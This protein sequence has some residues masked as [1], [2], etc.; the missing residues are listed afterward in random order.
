QF[1]ARAAGP[2]HIRSAVLHLVPFQA[3]SCRHAEA[4]DFEIDLAG[5]EIDGVAIGLDL[6]RRDD[7][8]WVETLGNRLRTER[9]EQRGER[10][11]RPTCAAPH[12]Q[13]PTPDS[14][15]LWAMAVVTPPF[16]RPPARSSS[17]WSGCSRDRRC[18]L[19]TRRC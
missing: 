6:E 2:A 14:A 15:D 9:E 17:H 3:G 16:P 12:W 8:R 18:R 7:D 10:R 1:P 5:G 4:G 13:P 19:P 11:E